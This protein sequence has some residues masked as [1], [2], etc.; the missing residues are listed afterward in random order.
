METGSLLNL[1]KRSETGLEDNRPGEDKGFVAAKA[2]STLVANAARESVKD[3]LGPDVVSILES[4][5]LFENLTS[6]FEFDKHL[7]LIFGNGAKVLERMVV[8]ELYREIGMSYNSGEVFSYSDC[9][10]AAR[11]FCFVRARV[12]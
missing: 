7:S 5:G 8:K 6:P 10:D 11:E 12:K 9:I 2:F 1:T 4:N 3:T